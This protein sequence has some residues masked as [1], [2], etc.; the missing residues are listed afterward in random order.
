[1]YKKKATT[2][3]LEAEDLALLNSVR[4]TIIFDPSEPFA[5][6]DE[7]WLNGLPIDYIRRLRSP[8]AEFQVEWL[9]PTDQIIEE[10]VATL[11]DELVER[12]VAELQGS[13]AADT[14]ACRCA[15]LCPIRLLVSNTC[16]F[17]ALFLLSL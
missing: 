4:N 8:V 17:P 5:V 13:T 7:G 11:I 15:N 10:E 2:S 3:D 14:Q 12:T 6:P 9:V 16:R 1:M